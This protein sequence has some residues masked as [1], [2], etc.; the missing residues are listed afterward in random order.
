MTALG[1]TKTVYFYGSMGKK[2]GK[3]HQ[4]AFSN[5][6]QLLGGMVSRF[7]PQIKEEIR[8]GDWHL[9][10]GAKKVGNDLGPEDIEQNARLTKNSVHLVPAV[11]ASS[12]II[13]VIVGAVLIV[14]GL[15]FSQPWLV[16]IGASLVL[17]GVAEMLMKQPN[18]DQRALQDE[19]TSSIFNSA[20]NVTTQGGP[21]P[22]IY[23]TV[24]RASSVVINSDFSS[25]ETE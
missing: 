16:N 13:R 24:E 14:A 19:N 6:F 3:K 23:G 2:Y 17:G 7:G 9:Y 18:A 20:R 21:M 5:W 12:S 22:L 1:T 25:D 11:S 8:V 10:N 15:Y 4:F